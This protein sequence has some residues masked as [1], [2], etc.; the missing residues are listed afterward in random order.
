[1]FT[2]WAATA[3]AS[4][5]ATGRVCQAHFDPAAGAVG[6]AQAQ[7]RLEQVGY[8]NDA[9]QF[10]A[11]EYGQATDAAHAH[12]TGRFFHGIERRGGD[13]AALHDRGDP[14]IRW[15]R[16]GVQRTGGQAQIPVGDDAH[17][18]PFVDDG[19]VADGTLLHQPIGGRERGVRCDGLHRTLHDVLHQH[20]SFRQK[21]KAGTQAYNLRR[22]SASLN[23]ES[24]HD[25]GRSKR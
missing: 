19:Q 8:G 16:M 21:R 15:K 23:P 1:M 4:G 25:V 17:Q 5:Q 14:G 11:V 22:G 10:V 24:R 20:G 13:H 2:W 6:A 7:K 12:Q 3:E 18:T 9:H